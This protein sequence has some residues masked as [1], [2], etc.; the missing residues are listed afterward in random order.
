MKASRPW[1]RIYRHVI[2]AVP[3]FANPSG[4]IMTIGRRERLV[5]IARRFDA[6]VVT[7]DVYDFL[8]WPSSSPSTSAEVRFPN[9]AYVPRIVDVDRC[10]R[11]GYHTRQN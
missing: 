11:C 9:Q 5:R 10:V 3:T 2:Y 8:Q 1:R 7:D 6:L 4:R